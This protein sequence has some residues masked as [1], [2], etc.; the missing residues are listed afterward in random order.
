MKQKKINR[1]V[2]RLEHGDVTDTG[3]EAFV[4]YATP[5]LKLGTGWGGAISMR[6]GPSVQKELDELG[7]AE[8]TTAV[9][10]GAGEM[11]ADY[12]IHAVGPQFM[13]QDT[14]RKLHD[15]M[16]STL[17]AADKKGITKLAFPPMGAGFYG[18]P[19][20]LCAKVMFNAIKGFCSGETSLHEVSIV[21]ADS[22][23][24]PVFEA[25]LEAL[26]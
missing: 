10:S 4:Y 19:L 2:I 25:G 5:D 6:G 3:A 9:V 21:L 17:K 26:A 11:K 15:T 16:L 12:I 7:G 23:E 13:E 1:S 18:V 8:L 22:R 14:E 20:E 24:V